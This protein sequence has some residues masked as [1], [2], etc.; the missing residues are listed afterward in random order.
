MH[1]NNAHVL[2]FPDCARLDEPGVLAKAMAIYMWDCSVS[3]GVDH[4]N[5][6]WC[7]LSR[8]RCLRIR[9][10]PPEAADQVP[11]R[12]GKPVA[13]ARNIAT[14]DDYARSEMCTW[15]FFKPWTLEKRSLL[16]TTYAFTDM[17]LQLAA[18]QFRSA[19]V[20]VSER[21]DIHQFMPLKEGQPRDSLN[22]D[23]SAGTTPATYGDTIPASIQY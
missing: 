16:D 18:A 3:H 17:E 20:T 13:L 4:A 2:G 14:V 9:I 21:K 15:L 8:E 12:D 10:P 6:T 1:Y 11:T 23:G 19:L 22:P 5:Y 7:V